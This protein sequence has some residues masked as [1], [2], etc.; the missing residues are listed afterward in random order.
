[1]HA[2]EMRRCLERCDILGTQK[3]WA[4]IAPNMPQP[5][6]DADTL[7]VIHHARSQSVWLRLRDRAYSHRWL[8]DHGYPSGLPDDLKPKAERMYPVVVEGVGIAVK[9]T[10]R[11]MRPLVAEVHRAMTDAVLE[12]YADGHKGPEFVKARMQEARNK[13]LSRI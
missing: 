5:K 11:L 8:L 4:H 3:L 7:M 2:A 10:S 1:M 9:A 6:S 12:V 13:I